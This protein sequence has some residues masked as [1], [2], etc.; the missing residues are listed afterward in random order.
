[1]GLLASVRAILPVLCQAAWRDRIQ[2]RRPQ[3]VPPPP[4]DG[5]P[6]H[7]SILLP[8]RKP[9]PSCHLPHTLPAKGRLVTGCW[10]SSCKVNGWHNAAYPLGGANTQDSVAAAIF[11]QH[12]IRLL[13]TRAI[14]NWVFMCLWNTTTM[15]GLVSVVFPQIC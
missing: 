2:W 1:M 11:R 3:R 5:Y 13:V 10:G 12:W 4:G 6:I 15:C 14:L 9:P 7:C 8:P